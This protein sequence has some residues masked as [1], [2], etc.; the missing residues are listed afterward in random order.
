MKKLLRALCI[1]LATIAAF[2]LVSC[3]FITDSTPKTFEVSDEYFDLPTHKTSVQTSLGVNNASPTFSQTYAITV[4]SKCTV[5]LLSYTATITLYSNSNTEL[6]TLDYSSDKKVSANTLFY[7]EKAISYDTYAR[8]S[9]VT[10]T[11][12]GKS[13]ENPK[14]TTP[15]DKTL[16]VVPTISF[17]TNGG[18]VVDPITTSTLIEPPVTIKTDCLFLGW[19]LDGSFSVPVTFPFSPA[20]NVTLYADWLNLTKYSNCNNCSLKDWTGYDSTASFGITPTGYDFDLLESKNYYMQITVT[21]EVYYKRDYNFIGYVDSAPKYSVSLVNSKNI[22]TIK[23]DLSAPKNA[24]ENS[25]VYTSSMADLKNEKLTLK[26][27][28]ENIQN[29]VYFKNIKVTYRCCT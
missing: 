4:S 16:P 3:K 2:G 26:F 20:K 14:Y 23:K 21:Y 22:G 1:G 28:T 27:S 29:I 19:Y 13:T 7:I 24:T 6:Q 8:V 10:A 15:P 11:F 12:S 9:R 25:I 17:Q 5:A 18:T